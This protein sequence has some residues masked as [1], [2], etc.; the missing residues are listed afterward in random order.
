MQAITQVNLMDCGSRVRAV[1]ALWSKLVLG[2]LLSATSVSASAQIAFQAQFAFATIPNP[3]A[4]AVGDFTGD[5]KLDLAVAAE[6]NNRVYVY[7]GNGDGTFSYAIS[8]L[9]GTQPVA[10]MAIDLNHDGKLDLAV[11]NRQSGTVSILLGH[12]DATFN[13]AVAYTVGS[14]PESIAAGSFNPDGYTDLVTANSGDVCGPP[15]APC[16]STS[17]LRS[18]GDGTFY[19]ATTPS[20]QP[21][22]VPYNIATGLFHGCCDS[23][24]V[25]TN[26]NDNE[27]L[28]YLGDGGGG[29]PTVQGPVATL[30]A[31]AIVAADFDGDGKSDLVVSRSGYGDVSLRLGNGDGTFQAGSIYSEAST[32]GHPY[33]AATGDFD[34]DGFP[35]LALANYSDNS[36]AVLRDRTVGNGG[37]DT[38]L[39]FTGGLNNPGAIAVGDFNRD[40]KV[41]IVV[42]NL[43]A[44]NLTVFLNTSIPTDRI[45]ATGFE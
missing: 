20:L 37:F 24:F 21:G 42:A 19:L 7:T 22:Q 14:L 33:A 27:F 10:I 3:S 17:L 43:S 12:G 2:C 40:G 29:F 1:H 16:G 45:F 32:G 44:N 4:I 23:D 11:A 5:G 28:V 13:A 15:F 34:G 9:V 36:V 38:A 39:T 31:Y 30:S 6:G 35:D 25:I 18:Y 8:Y 41:D 26:A